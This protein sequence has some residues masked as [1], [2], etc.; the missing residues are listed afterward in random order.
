MSTIQDIQ[1]VVNTT[2]QKPSAG[3]TVEGQDRFL[4]LLVAQM[5][6]QDPLNPM[7]NAEVTTQL[8]QLNTVNGIER[9]NSTLAQMAATSNA[10][11]S[12]QAV[13]LVGREVLVEGNRLGFTGEPVHFGIDLP[14]AVDNLTITITDAAGRVVDS[15]DAG[16]QPKGA[17][18]LAWTGLDEAGEKL[19]VGYY[20]LSASAKAGGKDAAAVPL[21]GARVD[22]VGSGAAGIEL[23]L[24]GLGS[25]TLGDIKRFL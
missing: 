20:T 15:I 17:M 19:P 7:D 4:K 25:V 11:Q 16:A 23:E 1:N 5:Q 3:G 24:G 8:A 18:A 6:N 14:Q 9:L 21:I 22:S 2:T 13:T 12:L 10:Q